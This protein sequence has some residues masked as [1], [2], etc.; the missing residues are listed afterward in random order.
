MGE[1]ATSLIDTAGPAQYS[2]HG[3]IL[4]TDINYTSQFRF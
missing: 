1:R 2:L 3:S 4:H